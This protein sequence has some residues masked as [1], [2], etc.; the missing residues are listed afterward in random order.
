M[1]WQ[2]LVPSLPAASTSMPSTHGNAVLDEI[3][4]LLL[5]SGWRSFSSTPQG[6]HFRVRCLVLP[7]CLH[8]SW[9]CCCSCFTFIV[10]W[11]IPIPIDPPEW[12][13]HLT[14]H[15]HP[16]SFPRSIIPT[17][18]P[19]TSSLSF[20]HHHL[21]STFCVYVTSCSTFLVFFSEKT[22]QRHL[23]NTR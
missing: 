12:G 9:V 19:I 11:Y 22:I 15:R 23:T 4:L 18:F 16:C 2:T 1:S 6:V 21:N 14:V 10:F 8:A 3:I 20:T 5:L 17:T 7:T 13:G